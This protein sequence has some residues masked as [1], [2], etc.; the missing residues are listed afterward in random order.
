MGII[1]KKIIRETIR[2]FRNKTREYLK[3]K[4]DELATNSKNNNIINLYRGMNH[5]NKC[6]QPRS[7]LV[8]EDNGDL[9]ADSNNILNRRKN[10][11]SQLLNIHR[12]SD[13]R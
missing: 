1:L 3:D 12:S 6:Y 5:F 8:K 7:N 2:H 11:F 10:Y 4:I 13:I 9:F